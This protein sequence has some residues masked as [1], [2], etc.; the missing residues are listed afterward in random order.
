MK[1][2]RRDF[3]KG[4]GAGTALAGLSG[5]ARPERAEAKAEAKLTA[6]PMPREMES[7]LL[8]RLEADDITDPLAAHTVQIAPNMEPVIPHEA[9]R[10]RPSRSWQTSR[11]RPGKSRIS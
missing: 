1:L 2:S 8:D 10:P 4:V 5:I 7:V 6:A 9:R 3:V 11:R